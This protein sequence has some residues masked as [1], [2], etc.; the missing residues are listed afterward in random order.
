MQVDA[1]QKLVPAVQNAILIL[2]IL[3]ANGRAMGATEIARETKLNVSSTFNILRTLANERLISFDPDSKTYLLGMGLM[4]IATPLLGANP[5]DLIR[6]LLN[7]V[8]QQ[9]QVMIALWQITENERIVLIDRFTTPHIVQAMIS[10]NSRLP[11]F[12]G[13]VGR[14]YAAAKQ[15]SKAE[16]RTG[17]ETVRWQ[18]D[19]GFDAY[20]QDVIKA[21]G[22]RVAY[23]RGGLF[24][25]L[26]IVATLAR[27]GEDTPRIGLSTITIA[28]QHDDESLARVAASLKSVADQIECGI[29]GRALE[30]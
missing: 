2:R 23:D 16:T 3:A 28:G 15:L 8:A 12:S 1:R 14:C 17:Y 27:D 13:A 4:E 7:E 18:T 30:Q 26:E 25:G 6:P 20:W 22:T 5:T 10:Q 24:R 19:F 9:H 11:V 29:F 21:R